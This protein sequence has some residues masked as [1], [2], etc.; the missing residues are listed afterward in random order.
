MAGPR[1]TFNQKK[2]IMRGESQTIAGQAFSTTQPA[3]MY[4]QF[5]MSQAGRDQVKVQ[6]LEERSLG[7]RAFLTLV[8]NGGDV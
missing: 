8:R 2:R 7:M 4:R 1:R 6:P 5:D 3:A